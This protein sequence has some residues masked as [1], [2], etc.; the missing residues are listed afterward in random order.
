MTTSVLI[1]DDSGFARRQMARSIPDGWDVD[2]HFAENGKEAISAIKQG[3]ADV[4]FLDLNMPVMDGYQTMQIV[5][6]QDL[7]TLV[8]VVSGDVQ[9]EAHKKMLSLGAI[10]F[11]AKPIDNQKLCEILRQY[12]LYTG[13]ATSQGRSQ[14]VPIVEPRSQKSELD[15]YREMANVAMGRAGEQVAKLLGE[16]IQLPIPNVNLITNNELHMAISDVKSSDSLSAVSHGFI[17]AGI[18]GEALVIFNDANFSTMGKLLKY[19]H[20]S[21]KEEYELEVLMDISNILVGACVNALSEQLHVS[22][23]HNHPIILGRHCDIDQVL[24]TN[25]QRWDKIL[26]IEIAYAISSQDIQF[27]LLLLFPGNAMALV[28]EKLVNHTQ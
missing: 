1:C 26:A 14:K 9:P 6:E 24:E 4:M 18:N 5:K 20:K 21:T 11:I 12:G 25:S 22:F 13:E 3:K 27:D 19:H 8:I 28:Y 2:I 7:P 17:G 23:S 10:A 15:A 16:F